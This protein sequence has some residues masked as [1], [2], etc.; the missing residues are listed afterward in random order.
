MNIPKIGFQFSIMVFFL[1]ICCCKKTE[2]DPSCS[3]TTNDIKLFSEGIY[4]FTGT[5]TGPVNIDV[6]SHGFYW[7]E[8]AK[9]EKNGELIQLGILKSCQGFSCNV[10]KILPHTTYYVKAFAVIRSD[11]IFGDTR[12]FTT[13]DSIV[14]PIIDVDNNIY[15]PVDIGDQTWMNENLK[16]THYSDGTAIPFIEDRLKWFDNNRWT[17]AYC[18]YENYGAL[19]AQYGNLYTWPAAM[20]IGAPE[21]LKPGRV[22]GV[23]PVGWHLPSDDEWKQLEMFLGMSKEVADTRKWRGNDEGG[24]LKYPGTNFWISPNIGATNESGFKAMPGGWRD[25]A[26][27]FHNIGLSSRFW[28][29]T[30]EGDFAL[31]R[32]LNNNSSQIFYESD[33]VYLGISVRCVKDK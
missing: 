15:Y 27:Y 17:K 1:V 12:S 20:N 30:K 14:F 24:K 28:T 10:Y 4:T 7:S 8:S 23:C 19:A 25:G 32:Q 31:I 21:D 18:W 13:P 26:G 5:I 11:S 6:T 29:S 3:V 9:P 2:T 16:V 33:G 22:Q